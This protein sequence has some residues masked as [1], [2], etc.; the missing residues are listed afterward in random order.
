MHLNAGDLASVLESDLAI[1]GYDGSVEPYPGQSPE[2]YAM[3]A[4]RKSFLKKFHNG[5]RSSQR[6]QRA[7]DLFM[8]VNGSCL[9]YS[10]EKVV[11][12]EAEA[13]ALGEAKSFIYDFFYPN[14]GQGDQL[15]TLRKISEG[16][17]VGP[18]ASVGAETETFY[19]KVANGP[20][21]ST[22]EDLI[23]LYNQ[24]IYFNQLWAGC[25]KS[26]STKF[27]YKIVQ[28][29]RLGFV[30]KSTEISRTIC[31]EPVLNMMFQKGIATLIESRL[32]SSLGID[33]KTQQ[34][35][36]RWLALLGSKTGRFG[37]IDLSSASDSMS[38]SLVAEFFPPAVTRWLART[39]CD[40]T[41]LPDGSL[42]ELHMVSSMGNAF[43]FPLQTLFFSALVYGAYRAHDIKFIRSRADQQGNFA[44]NGDDIIVEAQCYNTVVRLLSICG[45]AVNVNKSFNSGLFRESCG[46]DY[47]CGYN[48]RGV[49]LQFLQH[50]GDFYSAINRLNRWSAR[51]RIGLPLTLSTLMEHVKFLPVPYDE[52]DAAGIKV[53][54][55]ML[56]SVKR[57]KFTGGVQ[58]RYRA[59]I[60]QQARL[61]YSIEDEPSRRLLR[62]SPNWFYNPDG[63]M[64][65]L[66]HG[67]IRR[68]SFSFRSID[69]SKSVTRTRF[70]SSW[71]WILPDWLERAG[72][73]EDWKVFTELNLTCEKG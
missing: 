39:R 71:D 41:I 31:T 56:R 65:A 38:N 8:K 66:L 49:Y 59:P 42:L 11:C 16:F 70:S 25:E 6:D 62:R 32:S 2:Q 20:L 50:A 24:A 21:T 7:L 15:L 9:D 55:S 34:K 4:L 58:Y 30:P 28:G 48:V 5:E 46:H 36:N 60:T 10:P 44:V 40:K 47:Y 22:S 12:T 61:P 64:L 33:L 69:R 17:G 72:F 13:I 52:D 57:S 43:T 3:M 45:F 19:S 53:P 23:D 51:H 18:G 1:H 14:D 35:R 37:T 26:R 67:S 27:G 68:G 54:F 63:L 73:G 29:S